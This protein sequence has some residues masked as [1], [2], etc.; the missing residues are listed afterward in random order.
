MG[1]FQMYLFASR[2]NAQVQRFVSW[3][4]DPFAVATDA[5]LLQWGKENQYVFPPPLLTD[6]TVSCESGEGQRS[7]ATGDS[8]TNV[9]DSAMVCNPVRNVSGGTNFDSSSIRPV[10]VPKRGK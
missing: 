2:H 6:S 1:P 3:K 4:P 7:N 8:N 9:A 10:K 5:L